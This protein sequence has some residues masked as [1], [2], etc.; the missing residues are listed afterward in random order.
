MLLFTLPYVIHAQDINVHS[1]KAVGRP[2]VLHK[3]MMARLANIPLGGKIAL[4]VGTAAVVGGLGWGASKMMKPTQDPNG[5]GPIGQ[6]QFPGQAIPQ[7]SGGQ[8]TQQQV[9]GQDSSATVVMP[10][11]SQGPVS[12]GN[13]FGSTQG[14]SVSTPPMQQTTQQAPAPMLSVGGQQF[15]AFPPPPM[16]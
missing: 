1:A 5:I 16:K 11:G 13:G 14:Q 7:Q 8:P 6:Q 9:T 3:R 10:P 4:G 2:K 15:K 12:Q